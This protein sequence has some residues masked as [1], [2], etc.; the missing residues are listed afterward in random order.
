MNS[1]KE[2][3]TY[4][5]AVANNSFYPKNLHF[6]F[7]HKIFKKERTKRKR[8]KKGDKKGTDLFIDSEK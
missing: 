7:L 2:N 3:K 8:D 5:S 1:I 6:P 4:Q